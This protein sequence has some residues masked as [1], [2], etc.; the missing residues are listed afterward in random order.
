MRDNFDRS[1]SS[2][3]ITMN[4]ATSPKEV[5]PKNIIERASLIDISA[6]KQWIAYITEDTTNDIKYLKIR[7]FKIPGIF[8][9]LETTDDSIST[10]NSGTNSD[11]PEKVDI[12][13]YILKDGTNYCYFLSI[14]PNGKRVALSFLK[15]NDDGA[16]ENQEK[17][18]N[19]DTII[20]KV[21]STDNCIRKAKRIKFKGRAVFLKNGNLALINKEILEVYDC[22]R[23]YKKIH[24]FNLYPLGATSGL[25]F[26]E[27]I[28]GLESLAK[29][30]YVHF[31]SHN[32]GSNPA[33]AKDIIRISKHIRH[34]VLTTTYRDHVSRVWSI[35]EDGVRLT[36]FH[37]LTM[38][39]IMAFSL[40]YKYLATFVEKDKSINIYNVKSGL[41]V[42]R[43]KQDEDKRSEKIVGDKNLDDFQLYVC[44]CHKS[45]YLAMV[46]IV[47]LER[48]DENGCERSTSKKN[49][50]ITFEVWNIVPEKSIYYDTE[51]IKI[52]WEMQDK[53]IQPFVYEE[54]KSESHGMPKFKVIYST[55]I[56]D[57]MSKIN[58]KDLDIFNINNQN[59]NKSNILWKSI[60]YTPPTSDSNSKSYG[61]DNANYIHELDN[62]LNDYN[63]LYCFQRNVGERFYLLRFGE[64]TAQLWQVS[65]F[66][67]GGEITNYDKLIYIRAFKA[68]FYGFNEAYKDTWSQIENDALEKSVNCFQNKDDGRIVIGIRRDERYE[69][70]PNNESH[71]TEELYLPI[72]YINDPNDTSFMYE[73]HYVESA[74]QALHYLWERIQ[75]RKYVNQDESQVNECIYLFIIWY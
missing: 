60:D 11:D 30:S 57:G 50:L 3:A 14:S 18:H 55:G 51:E 34:N 38:E 31:E 25:F 7:R 8:D 65:S 47:K 28:D 10:E 37:S 13:K 32:S 35:T 12:T 69:K 1:D 54:I 22:Q 62:D 68:P 20:F 53:F 5:L 29:T 26:L 70:N 40:D 33:A 48:T 67:K 46:S 58:V 17:V 59:Q 66:E 75:N 61:F 43:L 41:V 63:N 23:R 71:Y 6:N 19:P 21:G 74:C 49:A 24:W 73:Y 9:D 2:V 16:V 64:K 36:S 27:A 72:K 42:N 45:Q 4:T 56:D 44:F 52:D 15:M 39:E